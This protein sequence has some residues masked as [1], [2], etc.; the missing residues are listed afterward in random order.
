MK[1][2]GMVAITISID[3]YYIHAGMP[4]A[5]SDGGRPYAYTLDSS[6]FI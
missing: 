5:G 3:D 4:A 2:S 1:Y 6:A